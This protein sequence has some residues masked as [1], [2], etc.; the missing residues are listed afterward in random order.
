MIRFYIL[1]FLLEFVLISA[2]SYHRATM[3]EYFIDWKVIGACPQEKRGT[4]EILTDVRV[5]K[6]NRKAEVIGNVTYKIPFDDTISAKFNFA[7]LGSNLAWL[8]NAYSLTFPKACSGFSNMMGPIWI[9]LLK[10]M[11]M[12]TKC[13]T[14]KGVYIMSGY[15]VDSLLRNSAFPKQFIYG[16]YKIT[17][18]FLNNKNALLGCSYFIVDVLPLWQKKKHSGTE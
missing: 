10:H 13:P 16:R 1:S 8:P 4:D 3:G 17:I 9:D 14:P 5:T 6:R 11:K 12:S 18:E 15:D 2:Q 7:V